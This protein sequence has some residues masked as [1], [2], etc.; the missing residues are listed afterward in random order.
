MVL[1]AE[2]PPPIQ[3]SSVRTSDWHFAVDCLLKLIS[4]FAYISGNPQ[5]FVGLEESYVDKEA[6][7]FLLGFLSLYSFPDN[8]KKRVLLSNKKQLELLKI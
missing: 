7:Y 4:G 2:T 1:A 6:K 3:D 8:K 5:S